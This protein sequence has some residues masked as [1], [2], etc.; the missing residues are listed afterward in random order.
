[1]PTTKKQNF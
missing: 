1:L